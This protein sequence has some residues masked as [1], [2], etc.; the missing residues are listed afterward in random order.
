MLGQAAFELAKHGNGQY[1][2]ATAG[3]DVLAQPADLIG[4]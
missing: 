4:H 3:T 1:R 2:A